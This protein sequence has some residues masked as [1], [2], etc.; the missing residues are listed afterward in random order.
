MSS[1]IIYKR[2]D[3]PDRSPLSESLATELASMQAMPDETIDISDIPPL[4]DELWKHAVRNPF[5][6]S[7]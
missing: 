2:V 6:K 3:I 7:V 4:P 1:K 5:Y